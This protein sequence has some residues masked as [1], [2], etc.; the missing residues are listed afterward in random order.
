MDR[1]EVLAV[2]SRTGA[3]WLMLGNVERKDFEVF[4]LFQALSDETTAD[5]RARGFSFLGAAGIVDGSPQTCLEVPLDNETVDALSARVR[6]LVEAELERRIA[7]P[8][9]E[10][11]AMQAAF[12]LYMR[13]LM[14]LPDTRDDA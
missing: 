6:A 7:D 14:N 4:P 13:S 11:L 10:E 1:I 2:K 3:C 12:S 9:V 8:V 5:Y